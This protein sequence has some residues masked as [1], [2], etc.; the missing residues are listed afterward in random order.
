MGA[1]TVS[2]PRGH[3]AA[4]RK[5]K[6]AATAIGGSRTAR[7]VARA[8][9]VARSMFYLL[10]TYLTVRVAV[11]GGSPGRQTNANGALTVIAQDPIG[12]AAIAAA[13]LGFL[14][15]GVVRVAG[16]V[17][18]RS[19]Q[20]QQRMLTALQG[21]FYV[22]LTWVP[23][24]FLLGSRDTGSEQAQHT[25][26]ARVL[27]WP[28]GRFLIAGVGLVVLGVCG[29]QIRMA[30]RQD[31]TDGLGLRAAPRWVCRLVAAAGTVGIAA[32]ALVFLPVGVFLIVSAVQADPRHAKGLDA[33]LALLARQSWWG[34]AILGVVALGLGVFALYSL[35]E[36]RYRRVGRSS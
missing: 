33:E 12:M 32:R 16:A 25:E 7:G 17:R 36:A 1:T 6:K 24:S 5:A 15:L 19:A 10:L 26:T 31:F 34:P 30:L 23:L 8:G 4:Q 13:A 35:L 11:D 14:A 21:T 18:D 2:A 3:K 22:A 9:L 20:T 29:Y 28:G 27:G